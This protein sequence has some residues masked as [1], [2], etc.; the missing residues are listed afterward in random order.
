MELSPPHL[1][2]QNLRVHFDGIHALHGV[3]FQVSR[4]QIVT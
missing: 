1:E 3:S 2:V 4:G